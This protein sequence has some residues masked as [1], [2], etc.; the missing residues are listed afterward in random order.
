MKYNNHHHEGDHIKVSNA[1]KSDLAMLRKMITDEANT[2]E[3]FQVLRK[4]LKEL[5]NL[6]RVQLK[7]GPVSSRGDWVD[8]REAGRHL[9]EAADSG[10]ERYDANAAAGQSHR[11]RR[12]KDGVAKVATKP[13]VRSPKTEVKLQKQRPPPTQ[14]DHSKRALKPE[15]PFSPKKEPKIKSDISKNVMRPVL[16]SL[17]TKEAKTHKPPLPPSPNH[18]ARAAEQGVKPQEKKPLSP[19]EKARHRKFIIEQKQMMAHYQAK[20]LHDEVKEYH[21][22]RWS[23]RSQCLNVCEVRNQR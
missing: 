7:K 17:P 1:S 12:I 22:N 16:P 4:S 18:E 14:P 5:Q 20:K 6:R 15:L 8:I 10:K 19:E 9:F 3:T 13:K 21:K 2:N 23:D 11:I